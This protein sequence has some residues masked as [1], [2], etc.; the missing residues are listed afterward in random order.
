M[1]RYVIE[2]DVGELTMEMEEVEQTVRRSKE[3]LATMPGVVWIRSYIS[4]VEGKIYCEFNA[5]DPDAILEHAR[6]AGQR[7]DR[8]SE[9]A[10]EID[11]AMFV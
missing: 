1:P 2:R 8:I 11:P 9:I 5:P 3:V 4:T 7:V 6:R 10:F